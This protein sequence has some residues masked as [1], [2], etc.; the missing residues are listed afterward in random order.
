MALTRRYYKTARDGTIAGPFTYPYFDGCDVYID[1]TCDGLPVSADSLTVKDMVYAIIKNIGYSPEFITELEH[2]T[3]NQNL[4][5]R[6]LF[7]TEMTSTKSQAEFSQLL[8]LNRLLLTARIIT[9][10]GY[11]ENQKVLMA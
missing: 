9:Q 8:K 5:T 6:R 10:D 7:I 4:I 11:D 2:S 3:V 1:F